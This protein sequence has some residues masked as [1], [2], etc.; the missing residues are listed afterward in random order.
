MHGVIKAKR[1]NAGE[2]KVR[3]ILAEI[4][5]EAQI[6]RQY[7][8]DCS[9]KPEI[10]NSNSKYFGHTIHYDQNEKLGIFVVDFVDVF[11]RDGFFAKI[12]FHDT[13]VRKILIY[14]KKYAS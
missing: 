6:N 11:A 5:P 7:L 12:V 3:T 4:N 1:I 8:V 13:M 9:L 14:M 10:F 2:I